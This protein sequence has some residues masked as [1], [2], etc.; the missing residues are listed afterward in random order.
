MT[1]D[2]KLYGW[3]VADEWGE[4]MCC[5]IEPER[6]W[7]GYAGPWSEHGVVLGDALHSGHIHF[8]LGLPFVW[9]REKLQDVFMRLQFKPGYMYKIEV[10]GD[11]IN[12]GNV[13]FTDRYRIVAKFLRSE[14][15]PDGWIEVRPADEQAQ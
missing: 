10:L 5:N 11:V 6:T 14:T 4:L 2:D 8:E 13:A 9:A 7:R 1:D 12:L 15:A 3:I